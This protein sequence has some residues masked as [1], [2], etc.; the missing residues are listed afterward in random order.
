VKSGFTFSYGVTSPAS[1]Q[2]C[3]SGR[4]FMQPDAVT[5]KANRGAGQFYI[6]SFVAGGYDNSLRVFGT[7]NKA[8][9]KPIFR[10]SCIWRV[11]V[12]F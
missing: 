7:Q 2:G 5:S 8:N 4:N 11:L 1:S 9:S 6:S 3:Q 10:G 12:T